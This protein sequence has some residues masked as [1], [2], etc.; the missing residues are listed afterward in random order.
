MCLRYQRVNLRCI[1][2][3]FALERFHEDSA[4]VCSKCSVYTYV[5]LPERARACLSSSAIHRRLSIGMFR[6]A[7]LSV[8]LPAGKAPVPISLRNVRMGRAC[9]LSNEDTNTMGPG[10]SE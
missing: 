5:I 1:F 7:Q 8:L 6:K 3:T 4:D 10:D 2:Q 9:P